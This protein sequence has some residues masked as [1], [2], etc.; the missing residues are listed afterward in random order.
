MTYEQEGVYRRLLDHQWMEG[1]IPAD[2][3]VLAS[4]LPKMSR[5]RFLE[6]WPLVSGKFRP[7]GSD[8][9]VNDR[10]EVQRKIRDRY[11]KTQKANVD[12]RWEKARQRKE[13]QAVVGNTVVLPSNYS[14][15]SSSSSSSTS[16][17]NTEKNKSVSSA[18]SA[19]PAAMSPTVLAFPTIG[20]NGHVWDLTEAQVSEWATLFP[21]TD[22]LAEARKAL[23]WVRADPGRRK[24][25]GGMP[26]FL[27]G[28]L[29]RAVDRGRPA[30]ST[31][32]GSGMDR[33]AMLAAATKGF[34][35]T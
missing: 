8:R 11:I 6:I 14:S 18:A 19:E 3:Q 13:L 31:T 10:L 17:Q 30:G 12:A 22:I 9:L 25:P 21:S 20:A 33:T 24:T 15:S 23:A 1:S 32:T 28:W 4:L 34:L 29:S 5:D 2:P 26:R 16:T 7:R 27:V 35:D